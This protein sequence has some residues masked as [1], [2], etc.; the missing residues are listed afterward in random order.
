MLVKGSFTVVE[1]S[2]PKLE[3]GRLT[4]LPLLQVVFLAHRHLLTPTRASLLLPSEYRDT[5]K[6]VFT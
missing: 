3:A 5:G 1:L 4:L 6:A 2:T